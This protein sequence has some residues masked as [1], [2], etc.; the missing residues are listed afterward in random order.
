MI[1]AGEPLWV[2]L[3]PKVITFTTEAG[4]EADFQLL[5]DSVLFRWPAH[6]AVVRPASE[7]S[8]TASKVQM[9]ALGAG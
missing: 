2:N 9:A 8:G 1:R 7:G 5:N 4:V 6:R 3:K